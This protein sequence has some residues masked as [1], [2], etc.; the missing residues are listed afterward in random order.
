MG[1]VEQRRGRDA[2]TV[3]AHAAQPRVALYKDHLL[4]QV[5]CV[6]RRGITPGAGANYNNF[7]FN[8]IHN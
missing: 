2:P 7:R 4:A 1:R 3:E 8:G 6:K 5:R